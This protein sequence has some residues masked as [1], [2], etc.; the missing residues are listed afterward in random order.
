MNSFQG[1]PDGTRYTQVPN[2]LL[3]V[4]L[5]KIEDICILKCLLRVLWLHSQKT[6]FPRFLSYED[7]SNDTT[8]RAVTSADIDK[9]DRGLYDVLDQMVSMNILIGIDIQTDER[10]QEIYMPNTQEGRRAVRYFQGQGLY[11]EHRGRVRDLASETTHK[12]SIFSLYED[13]IG[14]IGHIVAEELKEAENQ[15]PSTWIESA[16][17]EAVLNNKRSWRYVEAILK[18]WSREGKGKSNGEPERYSKRPD[19][20]EWI[21]RYGLPRPSE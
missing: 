4:L 14:I 18:G 11:M 16:F 3:G 9:V 5:E 17:R 8:I 13:N 21:K 12:P 20:R 2:L 10:S 1:F 6:G 19:S 7:L 15:Y